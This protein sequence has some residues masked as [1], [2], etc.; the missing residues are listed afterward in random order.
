M[1]FDNSEFKLLHFLQAWVSLIS[2]SY[3]DLV[4]QSIG[5]ITGSNTDSAKAWL[6]QELIDTLFQSWCEIT[7]RFINE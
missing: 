2:L 6:L 3:E 5:L 1:I 4:P 7:S